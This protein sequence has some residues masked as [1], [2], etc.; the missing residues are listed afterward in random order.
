MKIQSEQVGSIPRRKEL[1][2]AYK[3][4]EANKLSAAELEKIAIEDTILTIKELE[5]TGSSIITDGEQRKF[6]GF[7]TYCFHCSELVRPGSVGLKFEDGH[8][9]YMPELSKYPFKYNE[10]AY[11]YLKTTLEN[12]KLKVKQ[13]VVSPSMLSLIYPAKGIVGYTKMEFI[14]D[15]VN[16]H[17]KE[18]KTCLSMGAEK[19]QIDF[20]EARFSLKLDPSGELLNDFVELINMVLVKLSKEEKSKIGIHTCSGADMDLT[21]S[22][23]VEYKYLLPQLLKIKAGSFYISLS[24]EKKP[25]EVLSLIQHYLQPDQHIFIGVTNP[26]D[27]IIETPEVVR[28]RV[29]L[30]AKYIPINQLGTTDD[31]GF[32]PFADDLGT[33]RETAYMKIKARIE[34]TKLAE[35]MLNKKE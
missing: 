13:A 35:Q 11:Q 30:A 23:D 20:T 33:T 29:L 32:A 31:C 16:E 27:P 5:E 17:L 3:L 24:S 6:N 10:Y 14:N 26:I 1:V 8:V 25:E 7:P 15:L 19:V 12:T 18:V 28:D 21:H 9:R 34:G 2:A 22:A 4:F